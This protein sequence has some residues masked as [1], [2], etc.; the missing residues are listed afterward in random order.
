MIL[1]D[2]ATMFPRYHEGVGEEAN[3]EA[4]KFDRLV[5]DENEELYPRCKTF[6]KL[7]FLIRVF[8][9]KCKHRITTTA[10]AGYL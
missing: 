2:V 1:R 3:T 6:S 9:F 8:L 7:S 5:E 4:K 10:F